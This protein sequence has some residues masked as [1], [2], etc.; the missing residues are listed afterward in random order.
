MIP[1]ANAYGPDPHDVDAESGYHDDEPAPARSAPI[2]RWKTVKEVQLVQGNLVLDCPV[3]PRLLHQVTDAKPGER[4]EFTHM[5]YSAATCDPADFDA[6]A[7]TLRQKL[8]AQPRHT[9]ALH[10]YY[11]VQR[12]R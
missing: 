9:E 4:D 11:Y 5:R 7:F 8:F 1:G 12:G 10:C 3:P 2:K 6:E